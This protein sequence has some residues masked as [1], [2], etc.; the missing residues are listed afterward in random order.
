MYTPTQ[1]VVATE[2]MLRTN[3]VFRCDE[4]S[5]LVGT[6]VLTQTQ[7]NEMLAKGIPA[8]TPSAGNTEMDSFEDVQFDL[9]TGGTSTNSFKPNGWPR[10]D[11]EPYKLRWLHNDIRKMAFLYT[12][13]AYQ[14][15]VELGEL[16]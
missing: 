4:P 14:R 16:K 10:P 6:N 9:N 2:A 5:W 15:M 11:I 12:Y 8:L 1:A 13:R 3:S 7:Q